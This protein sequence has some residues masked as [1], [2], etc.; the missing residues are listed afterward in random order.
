[1]KAAALTILFSISAFA[2]IGAPLAPVPIQQPLDNSGRTLGGSCLYTYAAGTTNQQLTYSDSALM[3]A[4]TDPVVINGFGRLPAIYLS[5]VAYKLVLSYPT[6]GSCP[7]SPGSVIWS[8]D[9]V[10]D[11]GAL[12]K[13]LLASTTGA[14]QIGF[15]QVGGTATTVDAALKLCPDASQYASFSAAIASLSPGGCLNITTPVNGPVTISVSATINCSIGGLIQATSNAAAITIASAS[16]VTLRGCAVNGEHSGSSFTGSCITIAGSSYIQITDSPGITN[17]GLYG[18]FEDGSSVGNSHIKIL[19]NAFSDNQA[20]AVFSQGAL[21]DEERAGNTADGTGAASNTH[22]FGAHAGY[23]GS[24]YGSVHALHWHHNV[25]TGASNNINEVGSFTAGYPIDSYPFDVD[26]DHNILQIAG[27]GTGGDSLALVQHATIDDEILDAQGNLFFVEPELICLHCTVHGIVEKN[28][29]PAQ[30]WGVSIDTGQDIDLSGFTVCGSVFVGSTYNPPTHPDIPVDDIRISNGKIQLQSGFVAAATAAGD[31]LAG[32][33]A[34]LNDANS[35]MNGLNVHDLDIYGVSY[36]DGVTAVL[37]ENDSCTPTATMNQPSI[38]YNRFANVQYGLGNKTNC[39]FISN[40]DYSH[41]QIGAMTSLGT[42][43]LTATNAAVVGTNT[44]FDASMIGATL[45]AVIAG[46]TTTGTISSIT[47]AHNLTL[48]AGWGGASVSAQPFS[49]TSTAQFLAGTSWSSIYY[50]NYGFFS[51]VPFGAVP[52][53]LLGAGSGGTPGAACSTLTG[54]VTGTPYSGSVQFTTTGSPSATTIVTL[55]VPPNTFNAAPFC[56]AFIA[57]ASNSTVIPI[58]QDM[59]TSTPTTIVLY[60]Y[61]TLTTGI[62][63]R[64][65]YSCQ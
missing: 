17:C 63:Y 56:S 27:M 12:L 65:Q 10:Y 37:L 48:S 45:T 41:N 38:H 20:D 57:Y 42:V 24:S 18:I 60:S 28:C 40:V 11:V 55:L 34:Q 30:V 14:A 32:V 35:T 36:T 22:V 64:I 16:Y 15:E 23:G 26:F 19:S 52:G 59:N 58:I 1:M 51:N 62:T 6:N 29:N 49:I 46:T 8:Q 61:S 54:A 7:S 31:E 53:C 47:D 5:A 25:E 9:E 50:S 33:W 39:P 13:V 21:F 2:Q 43:A 3:T 4:N 44:V